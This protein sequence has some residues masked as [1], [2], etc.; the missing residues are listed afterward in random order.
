MQSGLPLDSI[1]QYYMPFLFCWTR[2]AIHCASSSS[3]CHSSLQPLFEC[4]TKHVSNGKWNRPGTPIIP[5]LH[6]TF[7]GGRRSTVWSKRCTKLRFIPH[8]EH[9]LH[10]LEMFCSY[11]SVKEAMFICTNHIIK[12]ICCVYKYTVS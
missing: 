11:G 4:R 2:S 10:P 3:T 9:S 5:F 1:S 6:L 12:L 8:K 7:S